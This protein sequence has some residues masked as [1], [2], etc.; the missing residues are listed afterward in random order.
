MA[1][2]LCELNSLRAFAEEALTTETTTTTIPDVPTKRQTN[3]H[4]AHEC[5]LIWEDLYETK[6]KRKLEPGPHQYKSLEEL[7]A[8]LKELKSEYNL[9]VE[10]KR[11]DESDDSFVDYRDIRDQIKTQFIDECCDR[12]VRVQRDQLSKRLLKPR[13]VLPFGKGK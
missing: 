11:E 6:M 7:D 9:R 10:K 5:L 13:I 1:D 4:F 12:I 8:D 2:E 3:Y